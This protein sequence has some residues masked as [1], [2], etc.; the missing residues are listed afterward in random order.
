MSS[1][2]A[3][4]RFAKAWATCGTCS[5][6]FP[7]HQV[8]L[9]Y[10]YGWQCIEPNIW[11]TNCWAAGP[12]HDEIR[13]PYYP[14]EGTR[15]TPAPPVDPDEGIDT[16]I[17]TYDF[18]LYNQT[19]PTEIFRVTLGDTFVT[20]VPETTY[21]KTELGG[22]V[23]GGLSINNNQEWTLFIQDNA[24]GEP[25]MNY[26]QIIMPDTAVNWLGSYFSINA[27]GTL[28]YTAPA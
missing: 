11:G 10:R 17:N 26:E 27:N 3:Y 20:F 23:W 9:H 28:E 13:P 12:Q 19:D 22:R 25:T 16:D 21:T 6:A 8:R 5:L 4:P 1:V 24:A 15:R 7:A 14:G 2:G 18:W